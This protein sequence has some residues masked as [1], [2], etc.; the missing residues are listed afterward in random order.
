MEENA[1][2]YNT[3]IFKLQDDYGFPSLKGLTD[4]FST[5][6]KFIYCNPDAQCMIYLPTFG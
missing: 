1:G 6:I 2:V 4:F 5:F 3:F